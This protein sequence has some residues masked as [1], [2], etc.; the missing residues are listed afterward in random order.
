MVA[1]HQVCSPGSIHS[2][3][4][5]LRGSGVHLQPRSYLVQIL[6]RGLGFLQ[7]SLRRRKFEKMNKPL[8]LEIVKSWSQ[9]CALAK[10]LRRTENSWVDTAHYIGWNLCR[11][12]LTGNTQPQGFNGTQCERGT[13]KKQ[14]SVEAYLWPWFGEVKLGK[15]TDTSS[16]CPIGRGKL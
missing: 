13:K 3:M 9:I 16:I 5:W 4:I 10:L 2:R 11:D 15:S 6:A 1:E 12:C 7:E 14:S 8:Q